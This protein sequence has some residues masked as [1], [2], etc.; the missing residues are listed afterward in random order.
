MTQPPSFSAIIYTAIVY[1]FSFS[2][3]FWLHLHPESL[4]I[5]PLLML[6]PAAVSLA[7]RLQEGESIGKILAPLHL[8]ISGTTVLLSIL[9]PITIIFAIAAAVILL[10]YGSFDAGE[11]QMLTDFP[12]F[13]AFALGIMLV[14]GEE[15]G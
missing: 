11:L 13:S 10:G 4:G 8:N 7:M 14:L 15:Y 5:F 2:F 12:G 6:I 1:L 9:Y 3:V